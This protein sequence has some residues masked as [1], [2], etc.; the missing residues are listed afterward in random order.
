MGFQEEGDEEEPRTDPP[1]PPE[2]R[3]W[4]HPS[5]VAG[6][7]PLPAAWPLP[8]PAP[9]PSRTLVVG[10]MVSAALAG[11]MVA[12]G[13]M[14]ITRPTRVVVREVPMAAKPATTAVFTPSGVPSQSLAKR[15]A[16]S[17]VLVQA[18]KGDQWTDGTGVR[19]D[20]QGNLAVSSS[21]VDGADDVAVTGSDGTRF[22]AIVVGSDPA[23]GIATVRIDDEGGT[24]L[25]A[26]SI[27][28]EAGEPIA[29]IGAAAVSADGSTQQRV[30]TA[31]VSA[32]GV[33]TT[34]GELVLHDAFQLDRAA[35]D[36]AAGGLVVDARGHIVGIVL[37][38]SGTEELAIAV[39]AKEALAAA[40]GMRD[41]GAVRRAWLG[42]RAVDLSPRGAQMLEVPGGALL[43]EVEAGSPAATAG[44]AAGDVVTSVDGHAIGDASDL[45][46]ALRTWTPGERVTVTWHRGVDTKTAEVTLGG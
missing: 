26:A 15:L 20:G 2:D 23:T 35:P 36:E 42:V 34:V 6:G 38:G 18:A 11:A 27:A 17:L 19:I 8:K 40:R 24:P 16:P 10:A 31:S 43:N 3:L 25:D 29:V 30:V 28:P 33:R 1:L 45:V 13:L 14:W 5:E 22:A 46:V 21:L 12:M 9:A 39:P 7:T 37:D 32:V 4:R 41:D 44:M